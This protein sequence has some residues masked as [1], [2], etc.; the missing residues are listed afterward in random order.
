MFHPRFAFASDPERN[1]LHYVVHDLV[2]LRRDLFALRIR[3][4]GKVA[5]SDIEADAAQ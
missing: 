4:N 3:E 2:D 1:F 5:A